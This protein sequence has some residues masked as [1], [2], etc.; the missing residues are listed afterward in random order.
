[1]K[2][3]SLTF[4]LMAGVLLAE[5]LCAMCF[6]VAAV[7][8]E[9]NGRRHAFDIMLRGRED[10]LLG[11]IRDAEDPDDNVVVDQSELALPPDDV[12]EVRTTSGHQVGQSPDSSSALLAALSSHSANGYFNFKADGQS[13]RGLRTERVRVIDRE[14][15]GG[16]RRPVIIL[17]ASP[18][19]YLWH[20]VVEAVRFYIV[21]SALLILLTGIV[22]AWLLRRW[23]SPLR[24]LA[25]RAERV[26]SV[27]WDFTPPEDVLNTRELAPIASSIQNLLIGLRRS[28]ERQRQFTGDAAHEL[29]TSIAVVKSGLQL[30][31]MRERT[32]QEYESSIEGLLLDIQ[33]MEDLTSRMLTLARFEQATPDES[34]ATD[35]GKVLQLVVARLEPAMQLRQVAIEMPERDSATVNLSADDADLLCSNLLM[36]AGEH[37]R[38]GSTVKAT[39]RASAGSAELL[40]VDEG[41]G[42]PSEALPYV[43]ERFYR[44]DPSRSRV[45]GGAGLGLA[46]C[47]AIMDRCNGSIVI[48]SV[49]N[50]GTIVTVTLPLAISATTTTGA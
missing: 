19:D 50:R 7:I 3:R 9:M 34:A 16:L 11:A 14:E 23:L 8:H 21:A 46:I 32:A 10:S 1:M 22:I 39:L 36:N 41:E 29:K 31:S 25:L 13:Y 37:S 17:Y 27:S 38:P 43:F 35:I 42:I 45:N 20:E 24:E 28:F 33:R 47:K 15:H 12:Y 5:L 6:S 30:L 40:I 2:R 18:T 4:T 48:S 49:L 44:A 26:S